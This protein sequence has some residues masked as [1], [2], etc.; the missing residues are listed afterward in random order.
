MLKN[1]LI[2]PNGEELSSGSAGMGI[3]SLTLTQTVNAGQEL[4]V[5]SVCA[6]MLEATIYDGGTLHLAPGQGVTLYKVDDA[7]N[8]TP[9]GHFRLETVSRGGKNTYKILAYDHVAQ[10]DRDISQWLNGLSGWP[11]TLQDLAYMTARVCDLEVVGTFPDFT[12]EKFTANGLTARR[13]M[14]W[15]G[16]ASG[17][18]CKADAYGVLKFGWYTPA[19]EGELTVFSQTGGDYTV[20]PIDNVRLAL[21]EQDVGVCYPDTGENTYSIVGNYLFAGK[22][23]QQLRPIA[24]QLYERLKTAVYT[25]CTV[26]AKTELAFQPG[27]ILRLGDKDIYIMRKTQTGQLETLESTGSYNRSCPTVR[28]E[29]SMKSLT[30]QVLEVK[31]QLEGL[32]VENRRGEDALARLHL[33][34]DGIATEVSRQ[35]A[36]QE[37]LTTQ[38][39]QIAQS[40]TDISLQVKSLQEQG[41]SKVENEFGLTIDGSAVRIHRAGSEMENRLDETGMF[42]NRGL[43]PM[44][45]ADDKGVL[46]TDVTVRNYL[47]VGDHARFEDYGA[48]RTACFWI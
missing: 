31:A 5:G 20:A 46:A 40:A 39:T 32:Q 16:Q 37:N 47:V 1:L 17:Q 18:F 8:R 33:Q 34:V 19:P 27:H 36:Q 4:T 41:V 22:T 29:T 10:L 2:L 26:K 25:P 24:R 44:L 21:T 15:I 11:Y 45:R 7:G 48:D 43:T 9:M 28:N 14:E 35:N 23:T 42:V 6:D 30:G 12:V 13:L 38:L 3:G